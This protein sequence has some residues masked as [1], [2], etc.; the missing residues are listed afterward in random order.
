MSD[1]LIDDGITVAPEALRVQLA[2]L[3]Q[4]IDDLEEARK[5]LHVAWSLLGPTG[6][7]IAGCAWNA[8]ERRLELEAL[9]ESLEQ[10]IQTYTDAERQSEALMRGG[11]FGGLLA[12]LDSAGGSLL[13][14]PGRHLT[15]SDARHM[16]GQLLYGQLDALLVGPGLLGLLFGLGGA[17]TSLT[18]QA[19][20][21][22][23]GVA[24]AVIS[25]RGGVSVRQT[26]TVS[27]SAPRSVADL[28]SRVPSTDSQVRIER[29]GSQGSPKWVVYV[30][31][32]ASTSLG[33]STEPFDMQSNLR[34]VAGQ[35][36]ASEA[37]VRQAMSRAGIAAGDQVM[38]VGHSQGGLLAARVA[39]SSPYRVTQLV[40]VGAPL[41]TTAVTAPT[42][43][44][45]HRDDPVPLLAGAT[46]AS[47]A[48]ITVSTDSGAGGDPLAP[49]ELGS[50][51]R[52]AER[53]D[54]SA[55]PSLRAV[56]AR[57]QAFARG[58]GQG[59]EWQA[60][61]TSGVSR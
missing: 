24:A 52:T 17:E 37:A 31:G 7:S 34:A 21:R 11:L 55:D 54:A 14:I 43:A 51:L 48:R 30:A 60:E 6:G 56:E 20:G 38:L 35:N 15:A 29:Y 25:Q 32:T 47:S 42:L 53:I 36:S 41:G 10:C 58:T 5:Q 49:H 44:I 19:S 12:M 23:G 16:T 50:Y 4:Q 22:V 8:V 39:E 61:R 27:P 13:G 57:I 28:V 18:K 2:Q 46:E 40:T 45:A 59:T 1:L 9:A 33:S 3:R 26:G